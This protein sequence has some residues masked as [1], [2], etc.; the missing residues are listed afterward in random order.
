M[1]YTYYKGGLLHGQLNLE[2][3]FLGILCSSFEQLNR[4]TA[5]NREIFG[6][7]LVDIIKRR[8]GR[9]IIKI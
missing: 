8:R 7:I 5:Y 4:V 2:N 1:Y 6:R 3:N 9:K